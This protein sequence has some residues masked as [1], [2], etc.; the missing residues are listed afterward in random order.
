MAFYA[1]FM[2][3]F[4]AVGALFSDIYVNFAEFTINNLGALETVNRW[5][6]ILLLRENMLMQRF[7]QEKQFF[8]KKFEV[9]YFVKGDYI[10]S[11]YQ[12]IKFEL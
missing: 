8:L 10:F 4:L 1:V 2:E 5:E 12:V 9:S 11:N 3:I 6:F 7:L